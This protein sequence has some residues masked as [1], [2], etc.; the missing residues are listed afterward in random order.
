MDGGRDRRRNRHQR[1]PDR[2]FHRISKHPRSRW[3]WPEPAWRAKTLLVALAQ[4][5]DRY[6]EA[7]SLGGPVVILRAFT[8]ASSFA[9]G[10]RVRAEREGRSIEVRSTCGLDPSGFLKIHAK[11]TAWTR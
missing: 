11:I 4:A 7:L 10:R 3:P 1:E 8:E 6:S 2:S 5:C 9:V